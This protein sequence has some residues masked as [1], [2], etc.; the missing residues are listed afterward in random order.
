[1]KD[2]FRD[3]VFPFLVGAHAQVSENDPDQEG[4]TPLVALAGLAKRRFRAL[5][6]GFT[7]TQANHE[8]HLMDGR[9]KL[10]Q[11]LRHELSVAIL[12]SPFEFAMGFHFPRCGK[13]GRY[14]SA[15]R[16]EANESMS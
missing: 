5:A 9:R 16:L 4:K 15:S 8:R 12:F 13:A 3:A 6:R 7:A 14:F 11:A 2:E 10:G 1:M